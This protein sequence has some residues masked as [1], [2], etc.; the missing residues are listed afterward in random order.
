KFGIFSQIFPIFFWEL[1][2]FQSLD[3][4]GRSFRLEGLEKFRE[5]RIRMAALNR[6][7][8]GTAT[9]EAAVSTWSD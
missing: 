3:V 7:G 1:P 8:A 5:Y 4:D 2:F 9:E 6:N